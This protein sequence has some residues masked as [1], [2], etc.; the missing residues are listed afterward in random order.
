MARFIFYTTEGT[1][2]APDGE[3]IENC[4]ML[5]YADG[6]TL[7]EALESLLR[8]NTWI[9]ECGYE[10]LAACEVTGEPVYFLSTS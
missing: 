7:N 3:D 10:D 2:E 9:K 4:Q 1:T 8:E 6:K 5:G